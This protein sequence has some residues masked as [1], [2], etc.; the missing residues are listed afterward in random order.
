MEKC[1]RL[2]DISCN[3]NLPT[4]AYLQFKRPVGWLMT[5]A[6]RKD[7]GVVIA[8]INSKHNRLKKPIAMDKFPQILCGEKQRKNGHRTNHSAS[9][10]YRRND[11]Q[12]DN[13]KSNPTSQNGHPQRP[14]KSKCGRQS[15]NDWTPLHGW[16][17]WTLPTAPRKD[18]LRMPEDKL[19]KRAKPRVWHPH[20]GLY[21]QKSITQKDTCTPTFTV[22]LLIIAK[23]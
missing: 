12:N 3:N 16:W 18:S 23:T 7:P 15:V 19:S 10:Y 4:S 9:N 22:V 5:A 13:K 20:L 6:F 1:C 17:E 14:T 8:E 11:N 21:P 2:V